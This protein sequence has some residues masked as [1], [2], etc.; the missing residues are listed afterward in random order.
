MARVWDG[1]QSANEVAESQGQY[2]EYIG[3]K[4]PRPEDD[5]PYDIV[6]GEPVER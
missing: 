5:D 4:R 2:E 6:D 3:L 1:R